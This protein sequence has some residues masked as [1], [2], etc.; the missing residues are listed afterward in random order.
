MEKKKNI[1]DILPLELIRRIL[2]RVPASHLFRLKCVSKCWYSLISDPHFAELHFHHSPAST[3]AFFCIKNGT[4]AY[5]LY[6][7]ALV[8]SDDND[9][10]HLK[11]VM[12]WNPLTG[13]SRRISYS[14]IDSPIYNGFRLPDSARLYGFGYD[15]SRDDYLVVVA[16]SERQR[17]DHLDCLSLRTNSWIHLDAALPKPL[18]V[19]QR[20]SAGL[21]LN[22]AIHWVPLPIKDHRDAILIFDLKE[23]SFSTMSEPEL[24]CS[25]DY[26]SY[27]GLALLGG[28]LALYYHSRDSCST[29]IWVMKEYKVHSSW[30]LYQI[31]FL[32]F[33]PLCLFNNGGIIGEIILSDKIKKIKF[34]M[35]NVGE[36]L[37]PRVKYLCCGL[38][39]GAT[40]VMYTE[41]LLPLPR[42]IKDKDNKNMM[43]NRKR[44]ENEPSRTKQSLLHA[45]ITTIRASVFTISSYFFTKKFELVGSVDLRALGASIE[46]FSLPFPRKKKNEHSRFLVLGSCRGSPIKFTMNVLNN[47]M[48]LKVS[49]T[50]DS[51]KERELGANIQVNS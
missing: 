4:V 37:L 30:N 31:P 36:E 3:N 29:D 40:E 39:I 8:F 21:F 17:Q 22:G 45:W 27:P 25:Y 50:K 42:D 28:C 35:Y 6:L 15:A 33:Q 44:K 13:S 46:E 51:N 23:R 41:S 32:F 1:H 12:V 5:F 49:F 14:G 38:N 11:E 16:W 47:L 43:K 9:A 18:H 24:A 19:F 7:D 10:S 34:L 20:T 26:E 2:L 48:L